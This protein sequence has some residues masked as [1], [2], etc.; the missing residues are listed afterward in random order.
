M[1]LIKCLLLFL[2]LFQLKRAF[3]FQPILLDWFY[4]LVEDKHDQIAFYPMFDQC[5]DNGQGHLNIHLQFDLKLMSHRLPQYPSRIALIDQLNHHLVLMIHD[6]NQV[7]KHACLLPHKP[8]LI[9]IT[10][11]LRLNTFVPN[12]LAY[13][14][15]LSQMHQQLH[16]QEHHKIYAF[17]RILRLIML[18]PQIRHSLHQSL[19]LIQKAKCQ[20]LQDVQAS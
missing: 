3:Q 20:I 6:K 11:P 8:C 16:L 9:Q 5:L 17:G 15:F 12:L 14:A 18:V 13:Q 4:P 10:Q 2:W 1:V 19:N 7:K